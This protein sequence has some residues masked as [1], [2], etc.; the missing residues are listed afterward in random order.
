MASHVRAVVGIAGWFLTYPYAFAFAGPAMTTCTQGS[1]DAWVLALVL[2]SPALVLGCLLVA[3]ARPHHRWLRFG[4]SPYILTFAA[5]AAV[6]PSHFAPATLHGHHL[7]DVK[8]L[9]DTYGVAASWWHALYWPGQLTLLACFIGFLVW[10]ATPPN[11][12][13]AR[14]EL[15]LTADS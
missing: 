11:R 15:K 10:F 6:L 13:L 9:P 5:A 12:T 3:A 14:K 7:C 4:A 8:V 1:D 2:Y